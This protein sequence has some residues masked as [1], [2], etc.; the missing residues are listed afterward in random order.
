VA[1][2]SP[3]QQDRRMPATDIQVIAPAEVAA[4]RPDVVVLSLSDLLPEM[5][6]MLPDFEAAAHAGSTRRRWARRPV[7]ERRSVSAIAQ[8][9]FSTASTRPVTLGPAG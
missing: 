7:C 9:C 6:V 5:R 2:A 3:A 8:L 1:D 4:A